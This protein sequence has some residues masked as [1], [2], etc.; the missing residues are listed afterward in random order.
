MLETHPRLSD[1]LPVDLFIKNDKGEVMAIIHL[2]RG[3]RISRE[4]NLR[5]ND[6]AI[7]KMDGMD[8]LD[9]TR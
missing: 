8:N 6:R 3:C 1:T 5:T 4:R 7:G 2:W 9:G